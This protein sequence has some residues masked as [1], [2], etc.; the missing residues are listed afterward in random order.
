MKKLFGALF[1]FG[2]VLTMTSCGGGDA[3]SGESGGKKVL[4]RLKPETGF[5]QTLVM[6]LESTVKSGM[7]VKTIVEM[8][9]DM[10]VTGVEGNGDVN[11]TTTYKRMAMDMN[12][13]G[14]NVK[15]DS[16]T[17][18]IDPNDP[19]SVAFMGLKAMLDKPMPMVMN[20]LG[21][22]TKSFDVTT[23]Y[24][25]S[26][27]DIIG[28]DVVEQQSKQSDQMFENMFSVFPDNEIAIGESWQR[29]TTMTT[30]GGPIDVDMTYTLKSNEKGEYVVTLAGTMEGTVNQNGQKVKMKGEISGEL[31]LDEKTCWTKSASI[32]Q[33]MDMTVM[34]MTMQ[35][36]NEISIT[37]K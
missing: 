9:S 33:D 19:Q 23:L 21:K 36:V 1:L 6:K 37:T 17:D 35:A 30:G 16:S 15:Y 34:G 12:M 3:A 14:M 28:R 31:H 29:K 13:M 7:E 20:N 2:A 5:K 11:V 27:I 10:E 4:L 22:V 26:I 24:T 8:E 25:D 18:E 32:T